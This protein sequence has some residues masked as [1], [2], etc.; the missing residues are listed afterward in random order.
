MQNKRFLLAIVLV[1]FVTLVAAGAY[2]LGSSQQPP[3]PSGTSGLNEELLKILNSK[4]SKNMTVAVHGKITAVSD[5]SI[6]IEDQGANLTLAISDKTIVTKTMTLT[7][8]KTAL[9]PETIKIS[10]LKVG[11]IV[12]VFV[13]VG[14]DGIPQVFNIILS[15][16]S[17]PAASPSPSASPAK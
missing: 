13:S 11:D 3:A 16:V 8:G 12:D 9:P 4:L 1:V 2:Y 7:P 10:D 17:Q 6:T 14:A 5:K 15:P